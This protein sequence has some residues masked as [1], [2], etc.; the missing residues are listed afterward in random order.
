M[1]GG[2]EDLVGQV[3]FIRNTFGGQGDV[4]REEAAGE[5]FASQRGEDGF[6]AQARS[7][8]AFDQIRPQVE[9]VAMGVRQAGDGD[10]AGRWVWGRH[11][12]L[13]GDGL[14]QGEG[15]ELQFVEF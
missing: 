3:G 15:F 10:C 6:V 11:V 12:G 7:V 2:V 1:V 4:L 13:L 5:F 14:Q 8:L 9:V